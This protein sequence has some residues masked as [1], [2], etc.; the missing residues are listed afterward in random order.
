MEGDDEAAYGNDGN[1]D[2]D[3]G[4]DDDNVDYDGEY[5]DGALYDG[6]DDLADHGAS[7]MGGAGAASSGPA[8]SSLTCGKGARCIS[9]EQV[10]STL[11]EMARG[12]AEVACCSVDEAILLIA[13]YKWH[14]RR[15]QDALFSGDADAARSKIGVSALGPAGD[16][17]SPPAPPAGTAL[18]DTF[19]DE[20]SLD[21]CAYADGDACPRG[22]WFSSKTWLG[23]LHAAASDALTALTQTRCP[24]APECNELI[25]PRLF[26]RFVPELMPRLEAFRLRSFAEACPSPVFRRCP[27]P[28]CT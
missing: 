7:A 22:H 4:I 26:R 27:A 12:I 10:A 2:F 17:I 25:R 3:G 21:D 9:E 18:T 11:A 1:V 5:D 6:G 15:V 16:G 8:P 20:C 13:A 24:S 19:F 28:D 14:P 23:H